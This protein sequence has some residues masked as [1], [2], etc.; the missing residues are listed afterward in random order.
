[1]EERQRKAYFRRLIGRKILDTLLFM[2][3]C[4][5]IRWNIVHRDVMPLHSRIFY[6]LYDPYDRQESLIF[7]VLN[8]PV[9]LLTLVFAAVGFFTIR[10]EAARLTALREQ[11]TETIR[12]LRGQFPSYSPPEASVAVSTVFFAAL[13]GAAGYIISLI[14]D[15][16][17]GNIPFAADLGIVIA[18]ILALKIRTNI[19]MQSQ[20]RI[21]C[22]R[23]GCA[24]N[25]FGDDLEVTGTYYAPYEQ[26]LGKRTTKLTTTTSHYYPGLFG[27]KVRTEVDVN[28]TT[29]ERVRV[30]E[31]VKHENVRFTVHCPC[32]LQTYVATDSWVAES[33]KGKKSYVVRE[34]SSKSEHF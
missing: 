8:V 5:V 20:Y 2:L 24:A 3:T 30:Y 26:S 16:S 25:C 32:C 12:C 33:L 31:D 13:F 7:A 10:K 6:V 14:I 4:A 11:P 9:I 19:A 28:T 27:T 22:Q 18:V 21:P 1:M 15:K 23:C 29:D 34:H 17:F